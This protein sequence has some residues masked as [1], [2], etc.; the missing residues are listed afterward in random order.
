MQ[1]ESSDPQQTQPNSS[2]RHK[3]GRSFV[4]LGHKHWQG[5]IRNG[6]DKQ[7]GLFILLGFFPKV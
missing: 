3:V 6:I 7:K 1:E 4:F 5:K 2:A